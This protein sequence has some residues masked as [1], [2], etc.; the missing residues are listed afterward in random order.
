MNL[1]RRYLL[2]VLIIWLAFA[3]RLHQIETQSIW[4]DEG[5]SIFVANHALAKI[6]TIPAMDVH[7]PLY[8]AMLHGWM[9]LVGNSEFAL[10]Y[11]S[12]IFSLLT[13]AL[14]WTFAKHISSSNPVANLTAFLAAISPMYIAY[15]QEVRSYAMLTCLA[16][17]SCYLHWRLLNHQT[18]KVLKTFRVFKTPL[19]W[20]YV[21][22]TTACLYTHYFTIFLLLFQN[23]VWL[24]WVMGD[25]GN[26]VKQRRFAL[27]LTPSQREGG[28]VSPSLG[29]TE[30]GRNSTNSK[31]TLWLTTQISMVVLFLPQLRIATRQVTDYAN[32]NLLP[33]SLS[34]FLLHSWQAYTVGQRLDP[35]TAQW[36]SQVL[37]LIFAI[38]TG[39][40]LLRHHWAALYCLG[41]LFI[42]LST[43]F[44]VLQS[45]PS[46]EPRYLM[47]ITPTIFLIFGNG[48]GGILSLNGQTNTPLTMSGL[49]WLNRGTAVLLSL[50]LLVSLQ[51]YYQNQDYFK[52]DSAGVAQW[53]AQET[54]PND[55]VFV[56]V[57]HPFHYYVDRYNIPAPTR[58]LFVD[59]HTTAET[60]S[61]A[62]HDKARLFWLTWYGSDT[63]PRGVVEFLARKHG[64]PL[65]QKEFRG[66][67]AQWFSLPDQPF[68]LP[69]QL[70]PIEARF[71]EVLQLI[72]A[73]M[74]QNEAMQSQQTDHQAVWATL[75]YHLLQPTLV[76]YRASLRLRD[77]EGQVI[78]QLDKDLLN[79][80][81]FRTSAWPIEDSALN[82]ALNV[83][84]LPLP[85]DT[86]SGLYQLELV[87]YNA[88]P[89]YPSEGV[90]GSATND[91][92]A[93]I[94]GT[95]T[96]D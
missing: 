7:P 32:P 45:R 31:I 46:Y 69:N 39:M 27:P 30:R 1:S 89:P 57:P 25:L 42:P 87:I 79:D 13:V 12:L 52:D 54:T 47:L 68:S 11:L 34:H 49:D 15:A 35:M 64:Q 19:F 50:I 66:Y 95:V 84:L 60:L 70:P 38:A 20:S 21:L 17:A 86:V 90:S 76:N 3:L 85:P 61:R 4:W 29:R 14:L 26:R 83:Y 63:D 53:L 33:P 37:G 48:L 77:E 23:L 74:G 58:Y 65:G 9:S 40:F 82:Q 24:M 2:P 55:L 67:R 93:A 78:S 80:R 51:P 92:S 8:F 75:H 56:D 72:G 10:R 22:V 41:W 96:I 43:Y 6:A 18:L 71:G 16:V 5:H 73:D 28:L 62:G 94:I 91:G 88:E 81:H 36:G 44:L 59:V